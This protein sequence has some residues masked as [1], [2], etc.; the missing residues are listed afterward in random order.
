MPTTIKNISL[1]Q[2]LAQLIILL[3]TRFCVCQGL[4]AQNFEVY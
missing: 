4:I 1:S 2:N 3:Y